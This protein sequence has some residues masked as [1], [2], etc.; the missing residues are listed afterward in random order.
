MKNQQPKEGRISAWEQT[1]R[2][3]TGDPKIDPQEAARESAPESERWDPVPGSAGH[4]VPAT[5]SEDEDDEGRSTE[6]QLIEQ[7]IEDAER[8]QSRQAAKES[9]RNQ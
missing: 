9:Q 7:G 1:T 8:D 4:Q 6:E 3:L 5:A 2:E